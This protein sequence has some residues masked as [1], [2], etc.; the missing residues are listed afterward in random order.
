MAKFSEAVLP[1]EAGTID[2]VLVAKEGTTAHARVPFVT[3]VS[4]QERQFPPRRGVPGRSTIRRADESKRGPGRIEDG[5]LTK[6]GA[7]SCCW[8]TADGRQESR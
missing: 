7:L 4:G 5:K 6:I 3:A 8:R 2:C 1:C